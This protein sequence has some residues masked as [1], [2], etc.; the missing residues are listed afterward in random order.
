[1]YRFIER[2]IC[3]DRLSSATMLYGFEENEVKALRAEVQH[4]TQN[5]QQLASELDQVKRELQQAKGQ[6]HQTRHALRDVTNTAVVFESHRDIAHKQ[7]LKFRKL[8]DSALCDVVALENVTE[9][10]QEE[11]SD[12]SLAIASLQDELK[13][14]TS[15][16]LDN[17][18]VEFCF[19]TKSGGKKYSPCIRKLYYTLLADQIPPAKIGGI[20]KAILKTFIPSVDVEL[21]SL[22]K[23]RCAGYMRREELK[24]VSMAHKAALI[25]EQTQKGVLH[26][27]TDGTTKLQ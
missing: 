12:L 13:E 26:M 27:N 7:A 20:I 2:V 24:T 18:A 8:Y 11:N 17:S 23:E 21:L 3:S 15:V 14:A 5:V 4:C 16:T 9:R 6:L 25:S 10:M 19:Q 1:M 22:P